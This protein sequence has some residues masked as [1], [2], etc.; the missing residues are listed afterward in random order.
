MELIGT[1]EEAAEKWRDIGEISC[2]YGGDKS[3]ANLKTAFF[4]KL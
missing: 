3:P 4:R 2:F 1:A